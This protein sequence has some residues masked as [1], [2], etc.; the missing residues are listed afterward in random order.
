M[1]KIFGFVAVA[2]ALLVAGNA[3]AQMGI[4]VGYA[5]QTYLGTTTTTIL[6]T[7]VTAHDTMSM[8]GFF[9]GVDYNVNLSGDLNVN[10]G[11]QVR[12]NTNSEEATVLGVT[13]K[14]VYTQ[15]LIDVPILFNYG[16]ELSNDLKL[17]IFAG[18]TV[19]FGMSGKTTT[20]VTVAGTS[21]TSE[22]DWYGDNANLKQLDLA[23]TAGAAL[24]FSDI[25]L[26]GGYNMGL[27]N[28]GNADGFTRKGNN[29]FVGIGYNL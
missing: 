1:K 9:A 25:R 5:P 7:T 19:I 15:M 29:F 10:V 8:S 21:T 22:D 2:A 16:L 23:V 13:S 4:H 3:N 12:Y 27:L 14:G 24:T 17:S 6:G 20:T 28:T 26:F 11:A 18:P